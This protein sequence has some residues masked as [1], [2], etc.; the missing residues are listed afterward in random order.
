EKRFQAVLKTGAVDESQGSAFE[1]FKAIFTT[2]GDFK[3]RL[4][5]L[6]EAV[7][8]ALRK[9]RSSFDET[10]SGA[11]GFIKER[12][13]TA[14]DANGQGKPGE[15][16]VEPSFV[17]KHAARIAKGNFKDWQEPELAAFANHLRLITGI[18][19]TT[20]AIQE[21]RTP[22]RLETHIT[23][24]LEEKS[25]TPGLLNFKL[26]QQ[27]LDIPGWAADPTRNFLY[28]VQMWFY[29][30]V[31]HTN[32]RGQRN[33]PSHKRV[34][35]V[36]N[37]A[38]H[39]DYGLVQY[40]LGQFG[41]NMGILAARDYFYTNFWKST[42]FTHL[43]TTIPIER[44]AGSG[45]SLAFKN[46]MKYLDDGSPLLIFPEGTRSETGDIQPFKHG[47]GYLVAHTKA[48][49]LPVQI[50]GTHIALPKGK[51]VLRGRKVSVQIGKVIRYA[52]LEEE[53][54]GL[55]PTRTYDVIAR[56]IEK[57]VRSIEV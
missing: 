22:A 38:S 2:E 4:E 54:K 45:Y 7:P 5:K 26:P 56:K 17:K 53:T 29:K 1:A 44:E 40:A 28:R 8:A 52:T 27:G 33:I 35:V 46:G 25:K 50:D 15:S 30:N 20:E 32:I 49:V 42:F 19:I 55:S 23:K 24:I 9:A 36:A 10:T 51:T 39:L 12:F 48:D 14:P 47:L 41:Q 13:G 16:V 3:A 37:H 6:R 34:I 18:K 57:A 31:L 11:N 43:M 21:M